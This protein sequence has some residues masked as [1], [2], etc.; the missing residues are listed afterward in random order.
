[1]VTEKISKLLK[2]YRAYQALSELN[3]KP[4][5]NPLAAYECAKLA[6]K[7]RAIK[8]AYSQAQNGLIKEYGE[9]VIK[10]GKKTGEFQVSPESKRFKQFTEKSAELLN[11]EEKIEVDLIPFDLFTEA[12]GTTSLTPDFWEDFS[13][14][15]LDPKTKKSK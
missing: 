12:K 13:I 8:A 1:M 3:P 10:N 11:K 2:A 5:I 7:L 14:F 4:R 6:Q 15:I 9:E